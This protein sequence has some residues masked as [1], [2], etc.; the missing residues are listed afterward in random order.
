MIRIVDIGY[1]AYIRGNVAKRIRCTTVTIPD[2]EVGTPPQKRAEFKFL[3]DD[4]FVYRA[5]NALEFEHR[6]R[7]ESFDPNFRK[8][9]HADRKRLINETS[10]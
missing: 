8:L 2:F 9:N 1:V 3:P 10:P 7:R 5:M 4:S 6:D